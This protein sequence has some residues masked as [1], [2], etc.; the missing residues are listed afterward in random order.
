MKRKWIVWTGLLALV[1]AAL[2]LGGCVEIPIHEATGTVE[3]S[4]DVT[5]AVDLDV[6]TS[7]GRVTVRGVEGQTSVEVIALLRSRGDSMIAAANRVAQIVVEMLHNGN[8]VVLRYDA[9]AHPWDVRRYS[10]VDF[11]VTV[12][13]TVDAEVSTSNGRIEISDV[14]GILDLTTSN[15]AIEVTEAAGEVDASTSNGEIAVEAFEGVLNLGTS[16]GRVQMENITGVVD[17]RTSNGRIAFSGML[18]DGATHR[19]TTSNGRIDIALRSDASLIIEART[20]NASISTDLPLIGDTEGKE[21]N[22]VLNPPAT[23]TLTLETS[24]GGIEILG[25]L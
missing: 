25:I 24:N 6:S 3:G 20:S 14:V 4:F 22:A 2:A 19:M 21:W 10:G 12:P 1:G 23:G 16:N 9:S 7:N 18:I 15:G 8:H 17:A 11:E 5:G 13:T